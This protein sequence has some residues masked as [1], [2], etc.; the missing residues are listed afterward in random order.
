MTIYE[1]TQ[2]YLQLL[3]LAEDELTDPQTLDDTME[4]IQG[5]IEDKAD[6]YAKIMLQLYAQSDGLD[7]EIKRLT[8]KKR[9][10]DNNAKQLKN[11]LQQAME[12]T[13]KTK[14]KTDLFS[15]GIQKN[16]V[17]LVIDDA[18]KIPEE[19]LIA[20]APKVD[21]AGIKAALKAGQEFDWRHL[22]QSESLRIR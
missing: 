12:A 22:S 21:N 3:A 13:G 8:E 4:A 11:R 17:A 16:P 7:K 2:E 5:E 6:G 20:Q 1:L 18:E 19:F 14:F 15:F 9:A 10:I